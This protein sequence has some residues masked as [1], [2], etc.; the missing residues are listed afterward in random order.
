[1]AKVAFLGAGLM[2]RGMVLNLLKAGH[3]VRVY[4]RTLEKARPLED[5]GAVLCETPAR[6]AEGAEVIISMVGDNEASRAVWLGPDGALAGT[7][8]PG[9]IAVESSTLSRDWV[10]EL[11]RAAGNA[12]LAYLDCPVTG[13]PDGAN[14]GTLTLLMGGDGKTIEAAM[15][16]LSAYSN[17]CIHFGAT[18]TGAAYKVMVNL[19][20]A[21]QGTALAEGLLLAKK[22]GLDMEKVGLALKDGSV[23]GPHVRYL[24]D[25]MIGDDHDDVFFSARWRHKDAA[26]GMKLAGEVG[27]IMPTSSIATDFYEKTVERGFGGKNSSIV[28]KVID[29]SSS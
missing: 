15:G 24:V 3:G 29:E 11:E 16:V 2:G 4:N 10:L 26:Y 20:G 6:A 12:G 21:V 8:S 14:A 9:A 25:R 18:G 7:F 17:R 28:I 1:M 27:Q 13:G 23:A 19:M 5:A 22:A